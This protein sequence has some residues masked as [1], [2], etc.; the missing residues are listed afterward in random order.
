[1]RCRTTDYLTRFELARLI[2]IRVLQ[3][4]DH[5][6]PTD[7]DR[8]PEQQAVH[9]IKHGL[10]PAVVRRYL[11]DGTHEDRRVVDLKL[12]RAMLRFQLRD[13][14]TAPTPR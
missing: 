4:T 1:M 7:D 12:D 14:P 13:T 5:N 10:N 3:I 9:E 11:A 6:L 8:T 2:G